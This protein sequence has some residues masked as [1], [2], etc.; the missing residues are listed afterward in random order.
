MSN[1][2]L[3]IKQGDKPDFP[4]LEEKVLD[5]WDQVQAFERSVRER[6]EDK[7]F[8]FYDGPPFATGLPHYGH[9]LGSIMKDIMPRYWTMKGYRVERVWGW[10]CHGLPIENIVEKQLNLKHGRKDIE[11]LGIDKFNA[12]CRSAI[13]TFDAEWEKVIKRIGRWVDFKNSYKTMDTSFMESVWWAFKEL[14]DKDLVY[15]G[16][17]VILYCP[18]CSTPLS[19][20]E[21]AMDNSY[22]DVEDTSVYVK[23][24][25]RDKSNQYIL[26]WTT[27]PWTLIGNVA[28]AVSPQDTY[29]KIK[30]QGEELILAKDRLNIITGEYSILEEF[31]GKALENLLYEPLFDY[32]PIGEK[33]AYYVATADFVS[34]QEGT[35]VVH[36]AAMYGEDD[37][38]LAQAID[39]PLVDMLDEQGKFLDF[40]TPLKGVFFKKAEDYV[41]GQLEAKHLLFKSEKFTHSYPFCYRCDTP[42]YYTGIPAW[43]INI[44]KIKSKLI[45]QNEY[46]NWHPDHLKQGRFGKGLM[47]AP[48]WNISRSRYWGTPM[49]IWS[50]P[51]PDSN[52]DQPNYR[53]IGSIDE[54]KKWAVDPREV[55][56]ITDLHRE[57]IDGI[58]VWIDDDKTIKGVRIPEVFDCWVESGS[59]PYASEH[60][61]FE[62]R[63]KFTKRHPAQ[64]ISEYIAQTRAWFYT[65]HVMSVA[66]FDT[67]TFENALTTG[68]IMAEDGTKMSK[69]KRNFTDPML[70][71]DRYGVDSLRLYFASS[72]VMKTAENVNFS[73][74]TVNEIKKKVLNIFWNVYSFYALYDNGEQ[75]FDFPHKPTHVLDRWLVSKVS[76][77]SEQVI[78]S[79]D[80]Y[81]V[82]TASRLLMDFVNEFSTWWLRLSRDRLR[83]NTTNVE[84]LQVFRAT[85][86]RW[87]LLMAPFAPFLSELIYQNLVKQGLGSIH[88]EL[89]PDLAVIQSESRDKKLEQATAEVQKAIEKAHALRKDAMIKLRQPLQQVSVTSTEAK[90][91]DDL[92]EVMAQELNVKQVNWQLGN[93]LLVELDTTLTPELIAEGEAREIIRAI[94]QERKKLKTRLDE[95]VVVTLPSWPES[96]EEQI[97]TK[98]FA[99]K[100]EKGQT[101]QVRLA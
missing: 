59:M 61:P 29:V 17:K 98:V 46:I 70:L 35:G 58:K 47:T 79:M 92:L 73:E 51:S 39:L 30:Y 82:V 86:L 81:D 72:P 18:R 14:Y 5:Y 63:D 48:D 12:A 56:N 25:L 2:A 64:F 96:Y 23:F 60:F 27:T 62:N 94:Q 7:P 65:L 53:V 50:A 101:F 69:S 45:K 10:D 80:E 9:L 55:E 11:E 38:I 83:D 15:Q 89:L 57:Y 84:A 4:D 28:L 87:L 8:V 66:L 1:T 99:K 93:Q 91:E 33:K 37:F 31:S 97:K 41:L 90:P 42:L 52:S 13:F 100:L 71:V 32:L 16:R 24:K 20:F 22:K 21:I 85:L 3:K 75:A 78:N 68:T 49:P 44:Q 67:Y 19:N 95:E 6:P 74:A 54:L 77:L 88:L 76:I 34:M 26:A 40:V 36:T 43:F